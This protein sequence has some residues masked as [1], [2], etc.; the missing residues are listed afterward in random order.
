MIEQTGEEAHAYWVDCQIPMFTSM[1]LD[2]GTGK[3]IDTDAYG[4]SLLTFGIYMF[5][6][7]H[8]HLDLPVD[9]PTCVPACLPT[10][11][12]HESIHACMHA[13]TCP[14]PC[15]Q[16][17][18]LPKGW[19]HEIEEDGDLLGARRQRSECSWRLSGSSGSFQKYGYL[20][21]GPL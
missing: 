19:E 3:D 5:C 6:Y 7:T 11:F 8:P 4:T 17:Y 15:R 9:V 13:Y 2:V 1:C 21:L 10:C 12:L 20:I 16:E 18:G 14:T